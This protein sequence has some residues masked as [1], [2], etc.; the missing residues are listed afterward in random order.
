MKKIIFFLGSGLLVL[1]A[2]NSNK[3]TSATTGGT[4]ST[5]MSSDMKM[6][7]A[8]SNKQKA[9]ASVQAFSNHD[10]EGVFKD[11]T[12]NSVDYGDGSGAPMNNLDSSKAGMKAFFKSF[13]DVKAD[14]IIA[15][16]DGD[17]VA[18]LA[19]WSCTF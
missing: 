12:P 14:N 5:K 13:P 10:V 6:K 18:V 11:A 17:Y 19:D 15:L 1:S 2:C 3:G 4:D 8:E 7:M 16:A 9:I